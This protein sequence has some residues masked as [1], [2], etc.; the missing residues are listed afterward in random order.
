[1]ASSLTLR[2]VISNTTK[3]M[4]ITTYVL[5]TINWWTYIVMIA[6]IFLSCMPTEAGWEPETGQCAD[7]AGLVLG[8]VGV[9]STV[10]MD[11]MLIMLPTVI[12]WKCK[13]NKWKNRQVVGLLVFASV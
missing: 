12:L 4:R 9:I 6:G 5:L 7:D 3:Y 8:L 1:M 11:V 10:L 2:R 13:M